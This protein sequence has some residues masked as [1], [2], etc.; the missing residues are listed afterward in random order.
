LVL[1]AAAI[2]FLF[3]T[4][5]GVWD[6]TSALM[7]AVSAGVPTV[8]KFLGLFTSKNGTTTPSGGAS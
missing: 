2:A 8:L 1:L 7:A 3:A 4:Q 5:R 6:S